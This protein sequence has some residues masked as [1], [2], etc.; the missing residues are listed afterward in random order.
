MLVSMDTIKTLF[1]NTTIE[2]S[3]Q[4]Y[5]IKFYK[6]LGFMENGEEYLEDGI[7][8]IRMLLHP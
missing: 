8:H 5:L 3:A 1:K 4:T 7:P 2:L 6:D